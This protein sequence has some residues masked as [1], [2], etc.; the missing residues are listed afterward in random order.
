MIELAAT[1]DEHGVVA[2]QR[3]LEQN[4]RPAATDPAAGNAMLQAG[5]AALRQDDTNAAL[6]ALQQAVQQ[7]IIWD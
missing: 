1:N 6:T 7:D 5:L 3:M 2:M 4:P